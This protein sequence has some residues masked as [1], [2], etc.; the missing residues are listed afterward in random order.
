MTVETPEEFI[1]NVIPR[2]LAERKKRRGLDVTVQFLISGEQGGEWVVTIKED[3][4]HVR[5]GITSG[6]TITIE[7]AD[8]DLV[9]MVNGELSGAQAFVTGKLVFRGDMV[10]GVRLQRLGII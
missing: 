10:A 4:V 9:S 6:P 3:K 1:E 5:E 2:R 8:H 7:M